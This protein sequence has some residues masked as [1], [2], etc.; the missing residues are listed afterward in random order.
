MLAKQGDTVNSEK[1]YTKFLQTLEESDQTRYVYYKL[2][3]CDIFLDHSVR[4]KALNCLRDLKRHQTFSSMIVP[5][6][7]R[8]ARL[9]GNTS[10][11]E[12][13]RQVLDEFIPL[14]PEY[15]EGVYDKLTK[16]FNKFVAPPNKS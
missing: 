15:M 13:A 4:E 12:S 9:I 5:R 14:D 1:L 10:G 16:E 7:E 2:E 8:L 3:L 11:F 6:I